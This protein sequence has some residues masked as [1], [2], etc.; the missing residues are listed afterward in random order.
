[1]AHTAALDEAEQFLGQICGMVAGALERLR[2]Q[3]HVG[4][5][6]LFHI[7]SGLQMASK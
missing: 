1:M 5:V 6:L 2:H 3:Q 7:V 4:A